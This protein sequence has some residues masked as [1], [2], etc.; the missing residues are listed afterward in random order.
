MNR[1]LEP[2]QPWYRHLW[3]WLLMLGPFLVVVAGAVTAWLA[4]RSSDGLV[5]DD[6]YK[7]GLAINQV[8]SRDRRAAE[9]GLAAEMAFDPV[10]KVI[11]VVVRSE[12]A[13]MPAE[14]PKSLLLKLSHPTRNGLDQSLR[15]QRDESGG[16][17]AAPAGDLAGRWHVALEDD[18]GEWRLTATWDAVRQPVLAL[19]AAK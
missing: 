2:V 5:A 12:K 3:P 17:S 19:V 14:M 1:R 16:Y 18:A 9:L 8:T 7:Q 13:E 15:L 10:R 4:F 11:R 6:Y